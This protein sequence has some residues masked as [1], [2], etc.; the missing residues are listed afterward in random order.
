ML[1][2][3]KQLPCRGLV[4]MV[5]LYQATLS[6]LLGMQCRFTPSCSNYC[7]EALEKY[8]AIRGSLMGLKRV[9]RC[10]PFYKGGFDPV[11]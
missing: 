3:L 11:R 10:N 4:W 6:P 8:G 5:R 1:K 7:I 2:Q 9:V